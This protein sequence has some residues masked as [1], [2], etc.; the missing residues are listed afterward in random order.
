MHACIRACM[1]SVNDKR[2]MARSDLRGGIVECE[3]Q[4]IENIDLCVS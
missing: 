3:M 1:H 2:K 4:W